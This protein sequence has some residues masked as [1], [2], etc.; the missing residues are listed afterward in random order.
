M[1]NAA[2]FIVDRSTGHFWVVPL[3]TGRNRS[4]SKILAKTC[5]MTIEANMPF[6]D[7]I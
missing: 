5:S 4:R 1:T 2:Y 3:K 7:S 6:Y